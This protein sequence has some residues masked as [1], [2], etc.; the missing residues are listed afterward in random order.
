[1]PAQR[2]AISV[3]AALV[4]VNLLWAANPVMMKL[5]LADF[6]PLQ[7]AW[8]RIT[9]GLATLLLVY[10][11]LARA[12]GTGA[13]AAP[14]Q[15]SEPPTRRAAA[16][17]RMTAMGAIVFCITPLLITHGL[18]AS[19]AVH[20][21]FITGM[22]PIITILLAWVFLHERV[23]VGRWLT[24]GLALVGFALL[25]GVGSEWAG[26]LTATYLFGNTLLLA[27]MAGEA[28]FSILGA[29]LV[30]RIN[31][32]TIF[33]VALAT[34]AALLTV[35]LAATG[36]LP[37]PGQFT[38]RSILGLV[39]TAPITTTVCYL[40]WLTVLRVVPVNA[41]A[42]TLFLQPLIGAALGYLVLG[43]RLNALQSVGAAVILVS[44]TL[45]LRQAA[46][47]QASRV[48]TAV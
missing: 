11:L 47:D 39:W 35:V 40:V 2:I 44:L 30:R 29:P 20:N 23:R 16:W 36:T 1:M 26:L 22:E 18:D 25:S 12:A 31:P 32:A 38:A 45:Y 7:A 6:E 4:A 10:P 15:P 34:G 5:V 42:F 46:P 19:L 37:S 3:L 41:A 17:V 9:C 43:E 27:G 13:F 24:I 28:M 33:L 21:A 14:R 48:T 8:L